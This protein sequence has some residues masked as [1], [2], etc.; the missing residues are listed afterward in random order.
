MGK[1]QTA[2]CTTAH[3]G[4]RV[5]SATKA[6]FVFQKPARRLTILALL[7][8]AGCAAHRQLDYATAPVNNAGVEQIFV[9]TT[10]LKTTPDQAFDANRAFESAYAEFAVSI[11]ASHA[12]GTIEWPGRK[13]KPG[14]DFVTIKANEIVGATRFRSA[15]NAAFARLPAGKRDAVVFVHGFNNTFVEGLYRVAQ[16]S[17]DMQVG[18]VK[19][20]YSW[21]SAGTE[22]G[23]AYDRDSATFARDGLQELLETLAASNAD[24]VLLVAHSMGA[25]IT[26]EALRQMYIAGHPR[27]A[28]K[29]SG[30]VLMSPDIDVDV[31]KSQLMKIKPL[32]RPFVIFSS[33]KDR[34]LRLSALIR[35][36]KQ[37]LGN[38]ISADALAG[39]GVIVI[40]LSNFDTGGDWLRHSSIATSPNLQA[41][42]GS[43]PDLDKRLEPRKTGAHVL[44]PNLV[45]LQK[46][47]YWLVPGF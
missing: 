26:V 46:N 23:Y 21:P 33:N 3:R 2:C 29:L 36:E 1:V 4:K 24:H 32:P 10:R 45:Q 11:P 14:T 17:H 22:S 47:G 34:A 39:L 9:A 20:H 12:S 25:Q 30:V 35:G 27:L 42:L 19:V 37:R 41:I 31:F 13:V 18:G 40:D 44:F 6:Y 38:L 43:L 15:L 5:L 7:L 16:L 8:L 28:G